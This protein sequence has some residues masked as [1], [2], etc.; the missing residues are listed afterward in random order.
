VFLEDLEVKAVAKHI[1]VTGKLNTIISVTRK[2]NLEN[3]EVLNLE[4]KALKVR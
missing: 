2:L 3:L 4:A 1:K